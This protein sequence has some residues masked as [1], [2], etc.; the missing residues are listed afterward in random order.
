M[1]ES[2]EFYDIKEKSK[3]PIDRMARGGQDL[4][5]QDTLLRSSPPCQPIPGA[6]PGGSS[7]R[8]LL[9]QIPKPSGNTVMQPPTSVGGSAF[10]A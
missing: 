7:A 2:L 1:K 8:I 6:K 10:I 3:F 4:R 5:Q 9:Q